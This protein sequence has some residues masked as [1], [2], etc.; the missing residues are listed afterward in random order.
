M[1]DDDS[2]QRMLPARIRVAQNF[3]Q[4]CRGISEP[5]CGDEAFKRRDLTPRERSAYEASIETIRA[6]VIGELELVDTPPS[7]TPTVTETS[8]PSAAPPTGTQEAKSDETG[9]DEEAA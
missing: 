3:I 6:Y 7:K 1:F 8:P 5:C 4:F 9:D 2:D